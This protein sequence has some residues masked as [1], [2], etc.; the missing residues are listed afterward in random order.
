M[1]KPLRCAVSLSRVYLGITSLLSMSMAWN[2]TTR[3]A[4]RARSTLVGTKRRYSRFTPPTVST[5][6]A[7]SPC[8]AVTGGF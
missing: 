2:A 4:G 8:F 3:G 5:S 6:L 7:N 1:T